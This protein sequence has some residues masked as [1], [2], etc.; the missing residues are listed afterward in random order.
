MMQIQLQIADSSL[1]AEMKAVVR[2]LVIPAYTQCVEKCVTVPLCSV[3]RA[4]C[5]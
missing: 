1:R 2:S 3:P 4:A 5:G